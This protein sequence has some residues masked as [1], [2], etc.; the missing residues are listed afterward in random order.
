MFFVIGTRIRQYRKLRGFSRNALSEMANISPSYLSEIEATSKMP[1]LDTATKIAVALDVPMD[2]LL[3]DTRP[4]A[5]FTLNDLADKLKDENM[6]T[7]NHAIDFFEQLLR[8]A[9][10]Q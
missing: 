4:F 2:Y 1:S 9:K 7:L 6:D 8:L 10:E 5:L 3:R